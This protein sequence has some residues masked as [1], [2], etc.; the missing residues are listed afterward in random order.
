MSGSL[1]KNKSRQSKLNIVLKIQNNTASLPYEVNFR[2]LNGAKPRRVYGRICSLP[3]NE[4]CVY[5]SQN[6]KKYN[7]VSFR[8]F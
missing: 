5:G 3:L 7:E 8:F 1:G 4:M 2:L 6:K